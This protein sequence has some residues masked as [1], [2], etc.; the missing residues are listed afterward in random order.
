MV[1]DQ[2]VFDRAYIGYTPAAG[3][4]LRGGRMPLNFWQQNEQW[5][6]TDRNPDGVTVSYN[7]NGFTLNGGYFILDEGGWGD[8]SDV[9]MYQAVYSGETGG[10]GFTGAAG[11]A[12]VD[13]PAGIY[14]GEQYWIVS[15]QLK[16]ERWRVGADYIASDADAEDTAYVLQ[17]RYKLS[18]ALGLRLYYYNVEAFSMLGDGTY[19]QDNWPNPGNTGVTNFEGFRYQLD[20]KIAGNTKLDVRY[21]DGER[22][23]DP[24]VLPATG[25]DAVMSDRDRNRLQV[26]LTVKF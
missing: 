14:Q 9:F 17:G 10:L 5:W 1:D 24:A 18:D 25:S 22:I 23:T 6:D 19:S 15:G 11:G 16:G 7:A 20:Y 12:S 8:D 13:A 4:M 3:L 21:Y 26:N 2:V